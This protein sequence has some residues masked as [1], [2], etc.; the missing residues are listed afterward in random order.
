MPKIS[1]SHSIVRDGSNIVLEYTSEFD[2]STIRVVLNAN[3][4]LTLVEEGTN[5]VTLKSGDVKYSVD[6]NQSTSHSPA[7][8]EAYATSISQITN[9][10]ADNLVLASGDISNKSVNHKFGRNASVGTSWEDIWSVGGDYNFL[11]AA[12]TL[13]VIGLDANDTAAGTGAR[14][15][16]ICGLDATGLDISEAVATNGTSASSATSLSFLRVNRC[17]VSA[18]GTYGGSNFDDITIRVSGAG[19]TLASIQGAETT[20][21]ASYGAGQSELGVFSVPAGK[22]C[23]ITHLTI[24]VDGTKTINIKL[25]HRAD[26]DDI[27]APMSAR[28]TIWGLDAVGGYVTQE[29]DSYLTFTEKSDIWFRAITSTGT[30]AVDI[31]FDLILVD[32]VT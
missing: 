22:T 27:V 29:F 6:F 5:F 18:V 7:T 14:E 16:T 9:E 31:S 30:S 21:T 20:G 25:V 15:V 26:L 3:S 17:F 13:E 10:P 1:T 32:N 28:R 2:A 12:A 4:V 8:V 19:S 23:F 11:T 24:N